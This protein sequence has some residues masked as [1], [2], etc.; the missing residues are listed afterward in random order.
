MNRN[1]V[2]L[3]SIASLAFG[4]LCET[5]ETCS[6]C[7][8]CHSPVTTFYRP[9]YPTTTFYRP[10]WPVSSYSACYAPSCPTSFCPPACPTVCQPACPTVCQ[11]ACPTTVCRPICPTCP[12]SACE[13]ACP[14]TTYEQ[15]TFYKAGRSAN[16]QY[17][18]TSRPSLARNSTSQRPS[19]AV[20]QS[21]GAA[22]QVVKTAPK[23]APK[24]S[25]A[26]VVKQEPARA[27]LATV[28]TATVS[29][30]S[31]QNSGWTPVPAPKV[32]SNR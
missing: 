1:R 11:P 10:L 3:A 6:A 27:P 12:T 28:R 24:A 7:H 5:A 29:Q 17:G 18:V 8:A 15:Q 21:R 25:P 22:T 4:I 9:F 16:G 20:A 23:T 26:R 19:A 13:P 2:V 14:T 30:P 31:G 32:A